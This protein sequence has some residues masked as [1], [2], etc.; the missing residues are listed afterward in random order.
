[1]NNK[2]IQSYI[3]VFG[4]AGALIL[5]LKYKYMPKICLPKYIKLCR[6]IAEIDDGIARNELEANTINAKEII[7]LPKEESIKY[8]FRLF[9]QLYIDYSEE[10]LLEERKKLLKRL[11]ISKKYA[12]KPKQELKITSEF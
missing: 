8:R 3:A 4:A 5:F 9:W 11:R 1:M 2:K 6:E 7:F 10:R 12:K